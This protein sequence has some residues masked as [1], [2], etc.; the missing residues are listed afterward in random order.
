M[1]HGNTAINMIHG[2]QCPTPSVNYNVRFWQSCEAVGCCT[3]MHVAALR[4]SWLLHRHMLAAL[5]SSWLLSRHVVAALGSTGCC[6]WLSSGPYVT[7]RFGS[8]A[9]QLAVASVSLCKQPYDEAVGCCIG[10]CVSAA[11]RA[12]GCCSSMSLSAA[13]RNSWPLLSRHVVAALGSSGCCS[14]SSFGP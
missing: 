7:C 3:G 2:R 9:K 1:S 10:M 14:W 5:R 13:L 6:L 4:S 12:V 11:L 8:S